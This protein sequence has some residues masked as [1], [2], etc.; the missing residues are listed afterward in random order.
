MSDIHIRRTHT[1]TP[2][3]ARAAAERVA[4]DLRD[5]HQLDFEW[6]GDTLVFERSG[7][8]GQL[9]LDGDAV[10][11]RMKLGFLLAMFRGAFE[12]E[13]HKFFDEEF[14]SA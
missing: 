1:L 10:E 6:Q 4:A 9:E 12:A 5:K 8:S 2:E 11:I 13:I 7:V 3:Q 14:G